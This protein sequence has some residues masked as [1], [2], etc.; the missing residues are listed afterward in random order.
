MLRQTA[1]MARDMLDHADYLR[2]RVSQGRIE[3]LK[4]TALR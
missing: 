4:R 3:H 2:L 1:A